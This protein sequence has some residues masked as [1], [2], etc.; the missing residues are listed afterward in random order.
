MP[1]A[2]HSP[3]SDRAIVAALERIIAGLW[4]LAGVILVAGGG[5]VDY[6]SES[7]SCNG[8]S[9]AG[10]I[11]YTCTPSGSGV[12]GGLLILIGL[13]LLVIA[14]DKARDAGKGFLPPPPPFPSAVQG[15]PPPAINPPQPVSGFVACATCG[16]Q[17]PAGSR[18][19][20]RCGSPLAP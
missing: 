20:N 9:D 2:A 13:I 12:A 7:S 18:F 3:G 5:I 6:V 19:C 16:A 11:S 4:G 14:W 15:A 17:L 8:V 1:V 10:S